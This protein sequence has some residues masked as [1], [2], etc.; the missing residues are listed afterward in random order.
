[1][2]VNFAIVWLNIN[3]KKYYYPVIN[4]KI[5]QFFIGECKRQQP[6]CIDYKSLEKD[7]MEVLQNIKKRA[8][9]PGVYY[10]IKLMIPWLLPQVKHAVVLDFDLWIKQPISSITDEFKKFSSTN[11]I[12]VSSDI[13]SDK[14]YNELSFGVNGGVQLM[15]L[16]RMRTGFYEKILRNYS[17]KVGY[18][19]DQTVYSYLYY[20]Y[21]WLFYKMSCKFN[22]QLN[23]HFKIDPKKYECLDGCV[24]VHGNQPNFKKVIEMANYGNVL[25]LKQI[26]SRDLKPYF[27]NCFN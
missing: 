13:M 20:S 26:I 12:G 5:Q 17:G 24:I 10:V 1:M 6:S 23:T 8:R 21:P 15:N 11:I 19:G 18:L 22:R 3:Y 16:D 2:E 27:S 25:P 14:L 7:K 9:G 4:E